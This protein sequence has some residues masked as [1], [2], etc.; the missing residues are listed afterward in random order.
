MTANKNGILGNTVQSACSLL[1]KE[2]M[3]EVEERGDL[4]GEPAISINVNS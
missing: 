3:K 4:V 2:R 1:N